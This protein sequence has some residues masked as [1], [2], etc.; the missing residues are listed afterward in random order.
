MTLNCKNED[1]RGPKMLVLDPEAIG[2]YDTTDVRKT[3][4]S[5]SD[6]HLRTSYRDMEAL[7]IGSIWVKIRIYKYKSSGLLDVLG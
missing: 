2:I 5:R 6:Q 1:E 7:N 3:L 4:W